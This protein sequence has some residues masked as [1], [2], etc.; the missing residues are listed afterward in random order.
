MQTTNSKN[1]F[2]KQLTELMYQHRLVIITD[3]DNKTRV[4]E[5]EYENDYGRAYCINKDDCL[6]LCNI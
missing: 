1:E 3:T 6:D 2:L 4:V 5:F